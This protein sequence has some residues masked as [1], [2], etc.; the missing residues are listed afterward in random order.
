MEKLAEGFL[1]TYSDDFFE[2]FDKHKV[3][4]LFNKKEYRKINQEIC[5]LKERFMDRL[6]GLLLT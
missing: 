4:N 5:N 1:D 6:I 2:Y 3:L